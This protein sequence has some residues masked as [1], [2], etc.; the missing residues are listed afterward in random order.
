MSSK[1]PNPHCFAPEVSYF[2]SI[3]ASHSPGN[4]T[5][6]GVGQYPSPGSFGKLSMPGFCHLN[7]HKSKCNASER[8]LLERSRKTTIKDLRQP[9]YQKNSSGA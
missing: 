1:A 8:V 3:S 9:I 4:M 6:F 7:P 2:D 5:I